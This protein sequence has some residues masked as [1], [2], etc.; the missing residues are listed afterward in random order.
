M[1]SD[2]ELCHL[3]SCLNQTLHQGTTI[4]KGKKHKANGSS[5]VNS[6]MERGNGPSAQGLE[7][8]GFLT[9]YLLH[10]EREDGLAQLLIAKI[11]HLA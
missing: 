5:A 11:L 6:S 4:S 8:K 7:Q 9:Y 1:L 3:T 10:E 2:R